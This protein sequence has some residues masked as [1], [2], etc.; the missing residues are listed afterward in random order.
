MKYGGHG[1]S[2]ILLSAVPKM[3]QRGLSREAVDKILKENP[4]R[5]LTFV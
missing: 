5:W 2:H 1:F 4:Q 3:L